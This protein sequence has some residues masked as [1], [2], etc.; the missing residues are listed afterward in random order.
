VPCRRFRAADGLI[1]VVMAC[2]NARANGAVSLADELANLTSAFNPDSTT[3]GGGTW[4]DGDTLDFHDLGYSGTPAL[5]TPAL[6]NTI[7]D[8]MSANHHIFTCAWDGP[9]AAYA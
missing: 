2:T 1:L 9:P 4:T 3:W 6:T 7:Q 8:Q 5:G